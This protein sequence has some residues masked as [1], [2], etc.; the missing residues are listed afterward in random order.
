[1]IERHNG[2][3]VRFEQL[4]GHGT[5]EE[6]FDAVRTLTEFFLF[7]KTLTTQFCESNVP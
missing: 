3:H 6:T 5:S 7:K 2:V 1:M 4:S